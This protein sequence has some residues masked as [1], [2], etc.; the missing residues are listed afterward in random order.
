[1]RNAVRLMKLST[2]QP[3]STD[4]RHALFDL[5]K[6][7]TPD[8]PTQPPLPLYLFQQS[9]RTMADRYQPMVGS[10]GA[11]SGNAEA[12]GFLC[13]GGRESFFGRSGNHPGTPNIRK[14]TPDPFVVHS[15]SMSPDRG[16]WP[17]PLRIDFHILTLF[18]GC[19]LGTRANKQPGLIRA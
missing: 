14:K 3:H 4:G 5:P 6:G 7:K 1:M 18:P 2:A 17:R 19:S 11:A 8:R 15:R 9:R 10:V 16:S 13:E 12:I